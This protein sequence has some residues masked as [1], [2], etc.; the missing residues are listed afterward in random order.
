MWDAEL[1]RQRRL[2]YEAFVAGWQAGL[3]VRVTS[4]AVRAVV[5]QCFEMWLQEE[6]DERG[7]LGLPFR[8]RFDLPEPGRVPVQR[9]IAD[10][11]RPPPQHK[12]TTGS[13]EDL[14]GSS[15]K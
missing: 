5:E 11:E 6:V 2:L 14:E 7:V 8:R 10:Q 1:E 3:A 4:P 13:P 15:P 12:R 9:R